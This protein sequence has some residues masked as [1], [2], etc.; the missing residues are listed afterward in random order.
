MSEFED[1]DLDTDMDEVADL[2][3]FVNPPAGV[4]VYGIAW[5]GQDV[6]GSGD[7][8]QACI[9]IFYQKIDTVE[10]VNDRDPDAANGSIFSE[11]FGNN[12]N[13]K[14]FL[15]ARLKSIFGE[16][17]K[18]SMGPYIKAL[19]EKKMSE[20][21]LKMVTSIHKSTSKGTE[22]ENVRIKSIETISPVDLP[23]GFELFTYSPAES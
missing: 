21:M 4:H 2:I 15:K 20:Y 18:G 10:K 9:K 22:Y 12:D 8:E 1:F 17:I 7:S 3:G 13:G 14:K 6:M 23:E 11:N 19:G 5:A 16:D